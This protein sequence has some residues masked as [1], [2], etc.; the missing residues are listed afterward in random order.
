[1]PKKFPR[2]RS[3][4]AIFEPHKN[5]I[6]VRNNLGM[7]IINVY[8]L[9]FYLHARLK[10]LTRDKLFSFP[11]WQHLFKNENLQGSEHIFINSYI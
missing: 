5:R 3:P 2:L 9:C 6:N 10:Q 11:N 1:M 8:Y 7:F 4:T